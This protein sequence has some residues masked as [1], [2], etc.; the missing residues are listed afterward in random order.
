MKWWVDYRDMALLT[1]YG[2][3]ATAALAIGGFTTIQ[4]RREKTRV[5][6]IAYQA[7][8]LMKDWVKR[9]CAPRTSPLP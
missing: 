4:A 5:R 2:I 3:L 6:L 1:L 9:G 8:S 7:D